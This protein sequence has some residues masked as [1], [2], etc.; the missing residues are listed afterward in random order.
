MCYLPETYASSPRN[1]RTPTVAEIRAREAELRFYEQLQR[2]ALAELRSAGSLQRWKTRNALRAP[3]AAHLG[4]ENASTGC[5][6]HLPPLA[7]SSTVNHKVKEPLRLTNTGD[8]RKT[9]VA[10]P[11]RAP[12]KDDKPELGP[13]NMVRTGIV[14]PPVQLAA[15]KSV[16][17]ALTPR[18]TGTVPPSIL[19]TC[20]QAAIW[21]VPFVVELTICGHMYKIHFDPVISGTARVA[22][23]EKR[24]VN[25]VYEGHQETLAAFLRYEYT[26]RFSRL[27]RMSSTI[28]PANGSELRGAAFKTFINAVPKHA[29]VSLI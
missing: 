21:T 27:L 22:A 10:L 7:S 25:A 5:R 9:N 26:L 14:R 23:F 3:A 17:W 16:H 2:Q 6:Y 28:I 4:G 29:V 1:G 12:N 20:K 15:T 24:L 19:R 8:S 18:V 13:A 11:K